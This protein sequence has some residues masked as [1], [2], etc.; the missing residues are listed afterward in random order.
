MSILS[1]KT[2]LVSGVA[3][4]DSIA[5][6]VARQVQELGGE[7]A[8]AVFPRD[9]DSA[10]STIDGLTRSPLAVVPADLT[11]PEDLLA[12]EAK[13]R[14]EVGHVDAA[15]HAVAF[16]PSEALGGIL[17][18]A[19]ASAEVAFR[20]ST[21]SY[22]AL[23][24]TLANLAP[25]SG[26]SLVGLDF[27]N[28]QAWPVYNWMGPCKA[29][30][31]SLNQYLARDLGPA[32]IRS[33]LVAAGPLATRAASGIPGFDQLLH[34]WETR[35][36]LAWDAR[37]PAPVADAVCFLMSDLARSITGEVLH[38]DGGVHAVAAGLVELDGIGG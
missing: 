12:L 23:A 7:V 16:A 19:S 24:Q 4:A 9:M 13:L 17:N 10:S 20:T 1:G 35:S 29:A 26:A 6:A 37:D 33:N 15:L 38:V 34:T 32:R 11:N 21:H 18:V 2:V 31:R 14:A 27:E 28:S 30:L 8:L 22:A 25:P 5:F 3:R 36:P